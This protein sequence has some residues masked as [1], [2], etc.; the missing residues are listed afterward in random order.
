MKNKNFIKA[1]S[2]IYPQQ[3]K[4]DEILENILEGINKK[5][6]SNNTNYKLVLSLVILIVFIISFPKKEDFIEPNSLSRSNLFAIE[7]SPSFVYKD[8]SYIKSENSFSISKDESSINSNYSTDQA[9]ELSPFVESSLSEKDFLG[10]YLFTIEDSSNLLFGAKV[11]KSTKDKEKLIV[12]FNN[13]YEEYE[14]I[15]N[16]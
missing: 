14:I 6:I 3:N 4:K 5:S 11:Y 16:R 8:N 2:E 7:E 12:L 15:R 10:E 9:K 1:F 13:V